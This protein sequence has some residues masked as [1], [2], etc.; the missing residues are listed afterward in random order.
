[1]IT[2]SSVVANDRR[3]ILLLLLSRY[4]YLLIKIFN[5]FS[6]CSGLTTLIR[7]TTIQSQLCC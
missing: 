2:S 1:M 3:C 7:S 5:I 4:I 6:H